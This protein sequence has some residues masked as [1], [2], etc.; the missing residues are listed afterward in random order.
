MRKTLLI[1]LLLA[2]LLLCTACGGG[3]GETSS[4][5]DDPPV[6][7]PVLE[8]TLKQ[9]LNAACKGMV[10]GVAVEIT[11]GNLEGNT[12]AKEIFNQDTGCFSD[13]FIRLNFM[14]DQSEVFILALPKAGQEQKAVETVQLSAGPLEDLLSTLMMRRQPQPGDY[15]VQTLDDGLILLIISPERQ[16]VIDNLI[17]GPQPEEEEGGDTDAPE[18]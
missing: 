4:A 1:C 11:P 14:S 3:D 17:A 13:F 9:R 15:E 8:M 10:L 16:T 5:V 18:E 2:A 7:D 12:Y 6:D